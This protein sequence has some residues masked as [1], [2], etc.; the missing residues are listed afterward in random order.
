MDITHKDLINDQDFLREAIGW[1]VINWTPAISHWTS[2]LGDNPKGKCLELGCGPG[3]ISL[4][5]SVLGL[6]VTCSDLELPGQEVRELHAKY[7]VEHTIRYE[8]INALDI[9]YE[10]HFDYVVFKSVLGGVSRNGN[11]HHRHLVLSQIKK[12]L[13][14][15]GILLFAENSSGSALHQFFRKHFIKWGNDWN[16]ISLAEMKKELSIFELLYMNV[17]GFL[18]TFG[19]NE[20]QRRNLAWADKLFFDPIT[21]RS[22]KYI[23]YGS[24]K[25]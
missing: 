23:L 6:E 16:Y 17:N 19:R 12:C 10:N 8:A 1:D 7:G 3:G 9:P 14:D 18:G 22:W 5:L 24:A 15:G 21:P 25:A 13:K 2:A 20:N 4:Y 11:D